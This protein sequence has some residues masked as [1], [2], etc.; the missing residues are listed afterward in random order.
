MAAVIKAAT[1][2]IPLQITGTGSIKASG[3][4]KLPKGKKLKPGA[5]GSGSAIAA[6]GGTVPL[7]FTLNAAAKKYLAK[8]GK[9]T[10]TVTV[11]FTPDGGSPITDKFSVTFKA[12]K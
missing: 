3:V 7:S 2:T 11:T 5:A 12:K 10:V 4:A 9:L 1:A 8:K 6:G